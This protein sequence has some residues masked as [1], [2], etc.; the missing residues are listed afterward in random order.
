MRKII[1][2]TLPVYV[3]T[4][5]QISVHAQIDTLNQQA[6]QEDF[7]QFRE[8]LENNHCCLYEYTSKTRI[9]SMFDAHYRLIDQEMKF[10]DFF[11]LLAPITA[12][13]GCM[14]TATWMP[15]RYFISK[16]EMMFPLTLSLIDE[17]IVVNGSYRPINEVPRGSILL[18]INKIPVENIL[19]Q[20]RKITSADALNP[21][22]INA[23]MMT[24]FSLFYASVFGLP[25]QYEIKYLL[26][27]NGEPENKILTPTDH[28]SVRKVVFS[29]FNGPPLGFQM[30]AEKNTAIM[31]VPTFIYYDTVEY[32]QHF[33]DSCFHLIRKTGIDNLI[34]DVRGNGGGDPFCSSILFSYLQK[35]PVPY[36]AEAYGKY[37]TLA[38]PLPVP[39]DLFTG[40][41]YVLIDG[42]C[43]STNGHFC[44]L[45]KYHKIGKFIGT[46]SG[47]TYKCNAGKDTEFRLS[48]TQIIITV[49]RST[50]AAAVKDMVKTAIL[51][52]I[53]VKETY[54][55]FLEN[56]D[57]FLSMAFEQIEKDN[58]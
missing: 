18:E 33:M 47:A 27:G 37:A 35:S 14:H 8:I 38:D 30:L 43:G 12:K 7:R 45:L 29:N 17:K 46:P 54:D 58:P 19:N 32:F 20:L 41:L 13:I 28:E 50:Y 24:R 11:M 4:L 55:D 16:P 6:L 40:N 34:L 31:T 9:D 3:L 53:T 22:F 44:A 57:V 39:E 10:N 25:D 2:A 48:N 49:G 51:P 5:F 23:Q 26:P 52:D 42:S 21:Y 56:R 15:G 36:F 1:K